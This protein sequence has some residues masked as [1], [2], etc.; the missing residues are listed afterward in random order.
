M[1]IGDAGHLGELALRGLLQL[2]LAP[3]ELDEIGHHMSIPPLPR[4]PDR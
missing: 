1:R 3:D 2:V 4:R